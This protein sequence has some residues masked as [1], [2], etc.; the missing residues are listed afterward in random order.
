MKRAKI[1]AQ[2]AKNASKLH[3][4]VG[5]LLTSEESPFKHYEIRQ[6]YPV[7][8]VNLDYPSNRERFDWV[9]LGLNI[10]IEVHGIQHYKPVCFG[11]ITLD[12]AKRNFS[13]R[14]ELDEQKQRAA[15]EAL[16]AYVVV[17]YDEKNL[18]LGKLVT[19]IVEAME[20][21]SEGVYEPK[22]LKA[23]IQN[24]GFQKREG[25]YKWPTRKIQSKKFNQ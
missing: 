3:R 20:K 18:T 11:G 1:P 19:K 17:R 14:L 8:S 13:R 15:E 6:E 23:K 7:S 25:K 12:K 21:V 5:F 2:L 10:V 9:I 16:W 22:K 4:A 24:Q